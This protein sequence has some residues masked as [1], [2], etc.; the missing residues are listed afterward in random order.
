MTE[1]QKGP[2]KCEENINLIIE[3]HSNDHHHLVMSTKSR[4]ARL[5]KHHLGKY[6]E[7]YF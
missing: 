7:K 4:T 1:K 5:E 6:L 2:K 3:K